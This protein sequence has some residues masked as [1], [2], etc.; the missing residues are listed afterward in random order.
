M[1]LFRRRWNTHLNL[2]TSLSRLSHRIVAL[3]ECVVCA[4]FC[5]AVDCSFFYCFSAVL[6]I[7]L[8]CIIIFILCRLDDLID[9]SNPRSQQKK[10]VSIEIGPS[11]NN[12]QIP[13]SLHIHSQH[14]H[15]EVSGMSSGGVSSTDYA[16]GGGGSS[17]LMSALRRI[18]RFGSYQ[19]D[20]QQEPV[21]EEEE[22]PSQDERRTTIFARQ[23]HSIASRSS[24]I[25][26]G[27]RSSLTST[28]SSIDSQ[29]DMVPDTYCLSD[30]KIDAL[31]YI[32]THPGWRGMTLFF[33]L[34]LLFLPSINDI[35]LPN[36]ADGTVDGFLTLGFVILAIDIIIRC[37][38]DKGYFA[39]K[40]QGKYWTGLHDKFC[41]SCC[42]CSWLNVHAGSFMFWF[43][44]LALLTVLYKISYVNPNMQQP[45]YTHVMLSQHGFPLRGD[46]ATP[47]HFNLSLV[48]TVGRVGLMARFIRT[49]F[50]VQATSTLQ[51]LRIFYPPYWI[52]KFKLEH[53]RKR[54]EKRRHLTS[55]RVLASSSRHAKERNSE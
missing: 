22:R 52:Y 26:S 14:N 32:I 15:R 13:R 50:L 30:S 8:L 43:D 53:N 54:E 47:L 4:L 48:L 2:A 10:R 31:R 28:A 35:W 25:S 27:R 37:T 39:L 42:R 20:Y 5:A 49:S 3:R 33:I 51:W 46:H 7:Y 29:R 1:Q 12:A 18:S 9:D 19:T 34:L 24:Q 6:H 45:K 36:T 23:R 21:H 44:T 38:V 41:D 17:G 16:S 40:R 11:Y 55:Q